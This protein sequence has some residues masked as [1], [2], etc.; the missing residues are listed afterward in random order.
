MGLITVTDGDT[1]DYDYVEQE[2]KRY[3]ER[4]EVISIGYDP[5]N[6]KQFAAKMFGDG[7][8]MRP[9]SQSIMNISKPTKT[10]DELIRS[11]KYAHDGNKCTEW[12]F[13][14]VKLYQDANDNHKV[15]KGK[16]PDKKVDGVISIIMAVGEAIDENNKKS[17]YFEPVV[18]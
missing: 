2:I 9:F 3:C 7:V 17:W 5:A 15:I 13:G 11:K 8:N 16:D 4:Y 1:T 6:S 18:L 12:Q 14:N 10:V